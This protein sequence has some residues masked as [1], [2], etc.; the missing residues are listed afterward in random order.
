MDIEDINYEFERDRSEYLSSIRRQEREIELL[1]VGKGNSQQPCP[2]LYFVNSFPITLIVCCPCF[3]I[4][5]VFPSSQGIPHRVGGA[6]IKDATTSGK[7]DSPKT[8]MN[9]LIFRR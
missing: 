1:Q 3:C 4:V 5:V 9:L 7:G 2:L 6:K 8:H